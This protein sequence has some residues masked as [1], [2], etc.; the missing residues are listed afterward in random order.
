ML[1]T[2]E[3]YERVWKTLYDHAY[4]ADLPPERE[5]ETFERK[6]KGFTDWSVYEDKQHKMVLER[7]FNQLESALWSYLDG[8]AVKDFKDE[9][10]AFEPRHADWYHLSDSA[11]NLV[12]VL[13]ERI[14]NNG[15][16]PETQ[17]FDREFDIENPL[18]YFDDV[19]E[20]AMNFLCCLRKYVLKMYAEARLN[21]PPEQQ[22]LGNAK[23][24]K[25]RLKIL[26]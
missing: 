20:A 15:F 26:Y 2:K 16:S 7:H 21:R 22:E 18:E 8:S 25:K 12:D 9:M 19:N 10:Q 5:Y 1:T 3:T 13:N 23:R 24:P 4:G 17:E 14:E 6:T 11:K